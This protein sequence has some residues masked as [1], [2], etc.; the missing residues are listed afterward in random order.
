MIFFFSGGGVL[1]YMPP[2]LTDTAGVKTLRFIFCY[3]KIYFVLI[4][5]KVLLREIELIG[6]V[7]IPKKYHQLSFQFLLPLDP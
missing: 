4:H 3:T 5:V 7:I 1:E 6:K 2:S